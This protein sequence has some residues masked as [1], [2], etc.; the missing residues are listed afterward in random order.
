LSSTGM[1]TTTNFK[2]FAMTSQ[3][4]M[5]TTFDGLLGLS[6]PYYSVNFTTG[7]LFVQ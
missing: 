2:F 4:G 7:P 3:S 5:T 1:F 6:R